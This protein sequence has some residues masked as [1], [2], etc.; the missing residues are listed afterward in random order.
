MVIVDLVGVLVLY[1]HSKSTLSKLVSDIELV[2]FAVTCHISFYFQGEERV[3]SLENVIKDKR[4]EIKS[5]IELIEQ[6]NTGESFIR[7]LKF[8]EEA[9]T[10][11]LLRNFLLK[12]SLVNM[13]QS[14]ITADLFTFTVGN[15]IGKLHSLRSMYDTT[16][17]FCPIF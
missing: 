1:S 17:E 8:S 14:P 10:T 13:N 6:L 16:Y 4:T 12:I 3:I 9:T 11:A 2:I 15:I 7:A 5:L